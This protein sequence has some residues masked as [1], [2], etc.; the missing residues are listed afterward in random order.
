MGLNNMNELPSIFQ[1]CKPRPEIFAGSLPDALFA[2]DLWDVI[3]KNAHQDYQDP[4]R[5]FAGTYPAANIKL[6]LKDV[7]SRLSGGQDSTSTFRLETG[8]GGGKTHSLIATVHVARE[9]KNLAEQLDDYGMTSLPEPGRTRIAAFVGEDSDPLSG[10]EHEV[11]GEKFRTFTPWGQIALMA[12]GLTGYEE[13][14][15]NDIH[16]VAPSQGALEKALGAGPVLIL[17]DELILY[18]AR[19]HALPDDH[20]RRN[21]S[22][23]WPTFFQTL[24]S[25]AA[26]RPQTVVILTLPSEQDANRRITGEL[27]E[28]LPTVLDIVDEVEKTAARQARN[29]TPTQ[30]TERAA[31]LAR[32]LFESVEN[33][34]AAEIG[35][36]YISFYKQQRAAGVSIDPRAFEAGYR[37][38]LVA[39]YP[40]HP[41]LIR[42]FSERLADIPEF[43]ATRGA[44]RLIARMIR[45]VWERKDTLNPPLLLQVHHLDLTRGDLRDELLGRLGRT[46][47]ERGLDVDVVS[48]SGGTHATD[49]EAGWPWYA[50][51]EASLTVFLHSLPDGSRGVTASETALAVG[52]P[53]VDLAYVARGLQDTERKAWYMRSEGEHFLFRT[54]ASINKRFQEHLARLQ[55]EPGVVKGTLDD[56]IQRLYSGFSRFQVIL[57]P[58]DHTS[59]P[60]SPDR[61]R[62]VVIHYDKEC[63]QVGKGDRLNFT[64][65]IYST[66]GVNES[67]RGY[68]NNLVFL[69]AESTRLD[70]VKDAGRALIAWERVQ[71]DIETEQSNLAQA[72]GSDYQSLKKQARLGVSGV[73]VEFLALDNDL[74]HVV[75]KLGQQEIN[76]RT[77]V[78]EA[79]RIL[80]FP[81]GGRDDEYSLFATKGKGSLL[82][83]YRIDF[84]ELPE[85]KS[86]K[87]KSVRQPVAEGPILQCL[88]HN[89]KLVPEATAEQ[90]LVLAPALIKRPP[91]WKN[92]ERKISTEDLWDRIRREPEVPMILKPTDLLPTLREG[93]SAQPE[94]YWVYYNQGEK[95]LW[96]R[97]NAADLSPVVAINHFLYDPKSAVLDRITSV[98]A[99]STGEVWDHLWPKEGVT[100]QETVSALEL[101]SAAKICPHFPVLPERNVL[102]AVLQEGVRENRWVLFLRGPHLAIG[103]QE[104][105]EWPASPRFEES[106]ELWT[107]QAALDQG[108]Y[109]RKKKQGEE[110]SVPLT[111]QNLKSRCW[112]VGADRITTEDLERSARNIWNDASRP[113]IEDLL[114]TGLSAGLWDAWQQ[115]TNETYYT[116]DD[117]ALPRPQVGPFWTLAEPGSTLAKNLD[118]L[119]PGKGPQPVEHV[120]TPREV[121]TEI[122]NSMAAYRDVKIAELTLTV[123]QRDGFDNTLRA[124]WSDRPQSAHT[125]VS[126]SVGGQRN[127]EIGVETVN[128]SYEGK[129]EEVSILL[130]PFWPFQKGEFDLTIAVQFTFDPPISLTDPILET[131]RTAIMNANQGTL[132]GRVVPV[133]KSQGGV[134]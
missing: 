26:H 31:V 112:P 51:R 119:R 25:L 45:S 111:P 58:V 55:A 13:V 65:K 78:L 103:G 35:D 75:E 101:L 120:G 34:K 37:E 77:K 82:E 81:K 127:S 33:V 60:D 18:M 128:L 20:Q 59:I 95:K 36:A 23:Q 115:G 4:Y 12:G 43:Q 113:V 19:C 87:W 126:V 8:F 83:C 84:G 41:E 91:L 49:V 124:T 62:L 67:P 68:R 50:A 46:A 99:L 63:A 7:A 24:F 96:T 14:K 71:K 86:K 93:L 10:T 79:L 42:L 22:S 17:I 94:A 38:Q 44:L 32:R 21:I 5:F 61:L 123:N 105:H 121:L 133:R 116:K 100:H 70:G 109:P 64:K 76:V 89:Q 129:F 130:A 110:H 54:R 104:M 30:T 118:T 48:P 39:G 88:R 16:G 132:H 11:E 40:F 85:E 74:A 57:F 56:W 69:L 47:F 134:A 97:D 9:G 98:V 131:Y 102:W 29:L 114:R 108:F 53:G 72:I 52:R 15:E 122:W 90:P 3:Q 1:T 80:A 27:R 92:G 125:A 117:A 2:A 73:P 106:V 6:L 107:Y 28:L 66:S